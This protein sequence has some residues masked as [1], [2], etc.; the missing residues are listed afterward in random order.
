MNCVM[1]IEDW[2]GTVPAPAIL[3]PRPL[4]S[5]KQARSSSASG[6]RIRTLKR[7]D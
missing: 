3:K 6:A 7:H 5:G 4:W 2:D 1:G